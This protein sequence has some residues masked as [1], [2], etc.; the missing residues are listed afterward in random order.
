MPPKRA[1]SS[2]K[3]K[4]P[5]SDNEEEAPAAATASKKVK[6]DAAGTASV[7]SELAP[8]GQPT[9]KVLPVSI[10]FPPRP[11]GI[12]RIAAWNICGLAASQKKV[13]QQPVYQGM[14]FIL[15]AMQG[16]KYYIEAEDPDVL[17]LTETKVQCEILV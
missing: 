17:I 3:R 2:K 13:R 1:A 8:N 14:S 6:A 11:E 5:T 12:T 9:N 10:T 7:G 16:F 15:C 4:L